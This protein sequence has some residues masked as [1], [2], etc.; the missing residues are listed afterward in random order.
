M[1]VVVAE[2]ADRLLTVHPKQPNI[3]T[4]TLLSTG[5]THLLLLSI[6][7]LLDILCSTTIQAKVFT[8]VP[9][10]PLM[11][12]AMVFPTVKVLLQFPGN[13]TLSL[14]TVWALLGIGPAGLMEARLAMV[15]MIMA[16]L[17]HPRTNLPHIHSNSEA[18]VAR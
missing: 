5:G 3:L 12:Q 7:P 17:F 4:P 16:M 15:L 13:S 18:S 6:A 14:L 9:V 10:Q 8:R 11:L 2:A 1:V